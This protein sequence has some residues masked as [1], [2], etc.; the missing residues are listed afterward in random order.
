MIWNRPLALIGLIAIPIVFFISKYAHKQYHTVMN[1]F[2]KEM[3]A[4]LIVP[5]S[6]FFRRQET[7]FL[8]AATIA[9]VF[10]AGPKS[11][12]LDEKTN[13]SLGTRH[14]Y[15]FDVRSLCWQKI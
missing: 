8:L 15:L 11:T 12:E 13:K 3:Q 1:I 4:R 10:L 14:I 9:F 5:R 6:N 7:L 2:S